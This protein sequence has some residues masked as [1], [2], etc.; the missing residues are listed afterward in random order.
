MR[1]FITL[2]FI[3]FSFSSAFSQTSKLDELISEGI[4]LHDQGK[5]DEAIEKY[6]LA[7]S[8][9]KKSAWAH[10]ELSY[11]YFVTQQY[12]KAV[13]HSS[14]VINDNLEHQ[15]LSYVVLGNSYDLLKKPSKAIETYKEGLSKFPNSNLLYYNLALTHYNQKQYD[16]A[17]KAA[18]SAILAKPPHASSHL[19]LSATMNAKGQRIKSILPLYYYLMLEPNSKRSA[20]NYISLR[21][22]LASG[23]EKTD[24]KNIS[25]TIP[26]S[27]TLSDDFSAAETTIS[28]AAASQHLETNEGKTD[29]ELFIE[30]SQLIFSVL[31]SLKGDKTGF[32]WDLYVAT[33]SDINNSDKLEAYC[34]YISQSTNN[35]EITKWIEENTSKMNAFNEWLSTQALLNSPD[36]Y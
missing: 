13:K 2:T 22:Q 1:Q 24:N 27:N 10:Y 31:G 6:S 25:I 12:K 15:H 8:I 36:Y 23:V 34:Y 17:E 3:L 5:Y 30:S 19:I 26:L 16:D 21:K 4:E 35:L 18:I 33:L 14:K 9:D 32:W 28:F 7:L 20:I 11:T 29:I